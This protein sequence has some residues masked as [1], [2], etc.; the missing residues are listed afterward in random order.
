MYD[1]KRPVPE[2]TVAARCDSLASKTGWDTERYEQRRGSKI[3]LGIPDRR[4][5]HRIAG[6]RIWVELKAHTKHGRM[7]REQHRWILSELAA[8]GHATCID[9]A[10]T[11]G[12]IMQT[13]KYDADKAH[14]M[15]R[16]MVDRIA[17]RGYR[18]DNSTGGK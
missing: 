12:E 1:I 8:G 5:V 16:E 10:V 18:V 11:L 14:A 4:Y 3:T 9:S 7:T 13:L 2:S 6:L 17:E 15:C